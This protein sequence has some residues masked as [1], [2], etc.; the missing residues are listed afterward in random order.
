MVRCPVS[1]NAEPTELLVY[2][3]EIMPNFH[4]FPPTIPQKL[5]LAVTLESTS[6]PSVFFK[7]NFVPIR[8]YSYGKL[9]LLLMLKAM[10]I[11]SM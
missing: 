9:I 5:Y 10:E 8:Y 3:D 7:K 2:T 4:N 1:F 11:I 6:K